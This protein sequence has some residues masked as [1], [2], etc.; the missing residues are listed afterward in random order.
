MG[1]TG[2]TGATGPPGVT[3]RVVKDS[4]G[5][6][7]GKVI[8]RTD[9]GLAS[10]PAGTYF[11]RSVDHIHVLMF[12]PDRFSVQGV[13]T[14]SP[15]DVLAFDQNSTCDL[16]G[17]SPSYLV[18]VDNNVQALFSPPDFYV[19]SFATTHSAAFFAHPLFYP[20][21]L[22]EHH[23]ISS[24]FTYSDRHCTSG[25]LPYDVATSVPGILDLDSF[26]PPFEVVDVVQTP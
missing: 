21:D 15:C 18:T 26:T 7:V 11:F 16:S 3:T 8:D 13:C 20:S 19:S 6:T 5:V 14:L 24:Y 1:D 17:L 25:A 22:G 23:N 4:H 9:L 10:L 2:P 12:L